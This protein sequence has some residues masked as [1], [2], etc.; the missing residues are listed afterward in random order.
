MGER[1][2]CPKCGN[3]CSWI[4][5]DNGK[6]LCIHYYGY[7]VDEDGVK[8]KK[9]KRHYL[10]YVGKNA[11]KEDVE[12]LL[13][14][15]QYFWGKPGVFSIPQLEAKVKDLEKDLKEAD[16]DERKEIEEELKEAKEELE[17]MKEKAKYANITLRSPYD[18]DR[19]IKYIEESLELMKYQDSFDVQKVLDAFERFL[20]DVGKDGRATEAVR[21]FIERL[22]KELGLT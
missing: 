3:P 13:R 15:K 18:K 19:F 2:I 22:Q 21:K 6:V 14:E 17:K 10:L 8:R 16:E 4:N 1:I 9:T 5:I 20:L 7:I 12:K 11:K